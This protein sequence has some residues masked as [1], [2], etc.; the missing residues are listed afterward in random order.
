MKDQPSGLSAITKDLPFL[1]QQNQR[2]SPR[3]CD[4][5]LSESTRGRSFRSLLFEAYNKDEELEWIG[6]SGGGYKEKEMP[7]ILKKLKALETDGSP[8]V[9]KY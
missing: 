3:I 7:V 5:W 4:W 8:F 1:H 9:I 2:C 6:R